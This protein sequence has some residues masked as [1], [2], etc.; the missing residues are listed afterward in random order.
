[1][2][3]ARSSDAGDAP[4]RPSARS[5]RPPRSRT[6]AASSSTSSSDF[7]LAGR[8]GRP[9][10]LD[11]SFHVVGADPELE[12]DSYLVDGSPRKVVR[13]AGTSDNPILRLEGSSSRDDAEALRGSELL[14]ARE[15]VGL[16]ADEYWASDL[17]G[18]EVV[19]G[20]E[21]IGFVRRMS[22]LPSCEVLEVDRADGSELLV[23]MVR[24]AIRSIDVVARRIDVDM[25]FLAG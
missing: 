4:R 16:E 12:R 21:S 9:H 18:C 2:T 17:Q 25:E 20:S 19:D 11:G 13:R 14:V 10:G 1:M 23:P 24:D 15:E 7:V 5:S 3:T 8:V 6:T 22:A